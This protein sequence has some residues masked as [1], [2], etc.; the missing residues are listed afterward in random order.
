MPTLEAD[1]RQMTISE[2]TI[3]YISDVGGPVQPQDV[4]EATGKNPGSVRTEMTKMERS[5]QLSKPRHGYYDL[6]EDVESKPA[7]I[8]DPDR[9]LFAAVE[10]ENAELVKVPELTAGA[11]DEHDEAPNGGLVLPEHWIRQ[12]YGVQPE[13]LCIIRVRGDSMKDTLQAGQRVYAARY[14]G[15]PLQDGAI[16]ALRLPLGFAIKRI[17]FGHEGGQDVIWIWSDNE[18]YAQHRHHVT[19]DRFD[20][21]YE[22]IAQALDVSYAL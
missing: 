19:R 11:G 3:A 16:Y 1:F 2:A 10:N 22:V 13:R 8:E 20:E 14:A 17:R 5:G 18:Q 21:E 7:G 12:T 6:P 4:A 15:E 9:D